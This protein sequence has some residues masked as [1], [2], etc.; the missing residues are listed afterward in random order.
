LKFEKNK[1]TKKTDI[2]IL[3]EIEKIKGLE[4]TLREE[5]IFPVMTPGYLN[6]L[7]ENGLTKEETSRFVEGYKGYLEA[8]VSQV[9]SS[10]FESTYAENKGNLEGT[11]EGNYILE[12]MRKEGFKPQGE[13]AYDIRIDDLDKNLSGRTRNCLKNEEMEYVGQLVQKTE[14]EMLRTPNFGKKG[15]NELRGILAEHGLS[16]GMKI[17]YVAPEES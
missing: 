12:L 10:R 8:Y 3:R 14:G 2:E 7:E 16:F 1:M 17:N 9:V 5:E 13:K 4:R 15:L 11:A 6:V